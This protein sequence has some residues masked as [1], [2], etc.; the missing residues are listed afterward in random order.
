MSNA[1]LALRP[2][3]SAIW[4][5]YQLLQ[6]NSALFI[7]AIMEIDAVLLD[8]H[9]HLDHDQDE[10]RDKA[11][12]ILGQL[13]QECKLANLVSCKEQIERIKRQLQSVPIR[14]L[15]PLLSDLKGHI[16]Q[17]FIKRKFF[18][19][20]PSEQSYYD[21]SFIAPVIRDNFPSSITDLSEAGKCI[22]FKRP[23]AAVSHSMRALEVGLDALVKQLQ[24][25]PRDS[26]WSTILDECQ[27]VISNLPK[28]DRHFFAACATE[29]RNFQHAWRNH[30]MHFQ[31]DKPVYKFGE[32]LN[33]LSS[34]CSFFVHISPRLSESP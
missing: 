11:M 29:F 34:V 26:N 4:N 20:D 16:Q 15:V 33:I 2:S 18:L 30:V 32:A 25:R 3:H 24:V 10:L 23:T 5:L 14:Y 8:L 1:V 9:P 31:K 21:G 19:I 22:V 17:E 7:T 13:A 27:K 28:A 12:E 6:Y